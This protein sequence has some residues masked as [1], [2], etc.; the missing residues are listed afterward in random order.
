M[1]PQAKQLYYFL[2]ACSGNWRN[3][4]YVKCQD[5]K[6]DPGYLL[7]SDRDGQ[8]VIVAVQQFYE[9]TGVWIDP[10]ECCGQLT[11][12]GFEALYAQYLLWRCHASE[13]HPLRQ[14]SR[15]VF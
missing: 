5:T 3:S 9:L 7:A 11:E 15:K 13:E 2:V 12:G 1:N 4:I 14:L 8:P 6:D 10:I